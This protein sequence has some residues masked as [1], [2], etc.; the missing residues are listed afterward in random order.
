MTG[1]VLGIDPGPTHSAFALIDH[2]TRR[3]HLI[4]KVDNDHLRVWLPTTGVLDGG[5]VMGIEM[6]ASYGMPVGAEVF[7]T[8]VWVGR[9]IENSPSAAPVQLV[10]RP[11]VK[12]HH[13]HS[14]KAKDTNVVQALV[15]RFAPGAANFGKGT[16]AAPGWFY[17]FSKDRW[18]AYACAVAVADRVAGYVP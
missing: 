1:Y 16:K 4:D 15:D 13:C 17:G 14:R 6:V 9:F 7:D 2:A 12:L 18:Q 8:C 10:P 5:V 11:D 3:P